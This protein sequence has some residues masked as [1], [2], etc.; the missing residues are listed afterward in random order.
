MMTT[1]V[2]DAFERVAKTGGR[3]AVVIHDLH[4]GWS[5]LPA[6]EPEE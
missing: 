3:C 6:A 1:M 5:L 4:V 2:P